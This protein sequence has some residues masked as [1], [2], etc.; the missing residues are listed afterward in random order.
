MRRPG[1]VIA[2]A[3]PAPEL[4]LNGEHI[5]EVRADERLIGAFGF[6]ALR[7]DIRHALLINGRALEGT[8]LRADI[9]HIGGGVVAKIARIAGHGLMHHDQRFNVRKRD[10]LPQHRVA[11]AEDGGGG[12]DAQGERDNRSEGETRGFCNRTNGV[13]DV[14]HECHVCSLQ[15][16]YERSARRVRKFVGK[17]MDVLASYCSRDIAGT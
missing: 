11:D 15:R 4:W 10:R 16:H 5:E 2:G 14:A 8:A 13:A 9:G 12:A 17:R 1:L 7:H 6:P 3:E